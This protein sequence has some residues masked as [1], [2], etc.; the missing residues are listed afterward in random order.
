VG[1]RAI[2]LAAHAA[3]ETYSVLT[4]LP[5][6]ARLSTS[7]AATLI[8][9]RFDRIVALE[10]ETQVDLVHALANARVAGGAVYDALIALTAWQD[11]SA[12]LTRD[13]RAAATYET[14]GVDYEFVG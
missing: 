1:R 3:L 6:D 4:R 7:D 12:L 14:L 8:D 10:L 9:T 2:G 13:T 11:G 5:G